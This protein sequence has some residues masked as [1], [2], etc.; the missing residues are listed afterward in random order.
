MGGDHWL[1]GVGLGQ[2]DLVYPT[3][4]TAKDRFS[5]PETRFWND[6]IHHAH[7]EYLHL[8]SELGFLG[9]FLF[10][11][12]F[13]LL[14]RK[15]R[16][17]L[18]RESD[19]ARRILCYFLSLSLFSHLVIALF[20]YNFQTAP[21]AFFAMATMAFLVKLKGTEEKRTGGGARI[22]ALLLIPFLLL[23][24]SK[25]LVQSV[26]TKYYLHL[27]ESLLERS[28]PKATEAFEKAIQWN[29][30]DWRAWFFLGNISGDEGNYKQAIL[31]MKRSLEFNPYHVMTLYNL[32]LYYEKSKKYSKAIQAYRNVVS[33]APDFRMAHNRLGRIH[34]KKREWYDAKRYFWEALQPAAYQEGEMPKALFGLFLC[35]L[36]LKEWSK[37]M[38]LLGEIYLIHETDFTFHPNYFRLEGKYTD[39]FQWWLG[40]L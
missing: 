22:S 26:F 10:G 5:I 28:K 37:A 27:G 31:H 2:F 9:L 8:F 25:F 15:M 1:R 30:N 13:F 39:I 20:V 29:P 11:G 3:F 35:E 23:F 7:N 6:Y 18:K 17:Y 36:N 12:L 21:S 40:H 38:A 4:A 16:F 14:F 24:S 19:E 33:F 32:A 34:L